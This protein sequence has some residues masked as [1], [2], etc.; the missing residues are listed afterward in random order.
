MFSSFDFMFGE[1]HLK[2]RLQ[3]LVVNALSKAIM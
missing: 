1:H 3:Y 2:R